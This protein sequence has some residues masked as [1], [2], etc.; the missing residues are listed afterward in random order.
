M[1]LKPRVKCHPARG[2]MTTFNIN[3]YTDNLLLPRLI[4]YIQGGQVPGVS[5]TALYLLSAFAIQWLLRKLVHD[6]HAKFKPETKLS[7]PQGQPI[8]QSE[9]RVPPCVVSSEV[10]VSS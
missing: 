6:S 3:L 8:G 4:F 10:C 2:R 7:P 5:E 1:D 9:V